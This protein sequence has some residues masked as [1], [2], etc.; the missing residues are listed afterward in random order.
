MKE[1]L[2]FSLAI[3]F[4]LA[5]FNLLLEP[6]FERSMIY[7][8]ARE[9]EEDPEVLGIKYEDVFIKADDGATI[10]GWFIENKDSDKVVLYF[11]G[12]A[13][14]ISHRLPVIDLLYR[15]PVSILIIDYHGYGRSEGRPSE[16]NLYLDAEAAYHYLVTKKKYLPSQIILMGRSIGGVVAAHLASQKEVGGVIMEGSFTSAREM[17]RDM[18]FLFTRPI[19]WIRSDFNALEKVKAIEAP[20]LFIHSKQD[21]MIPYRMSVALYEEASEPKK[22]LLH[23]KGGHND[24]VITPEYVRHLMEIVSGK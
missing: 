17:A 10:H 13:G 15:L 5:V 22:L 6:F 20:K 2:G 3:L 11:H 12:N 24:F 16:K 8:P 4:F 1:I 19:V 23:E 21:E 18:L 7:F 9:I 14:N